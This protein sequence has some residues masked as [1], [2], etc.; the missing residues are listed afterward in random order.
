MKFRRQH[1]IGPFVVDFCCPDRRLV[2]ELDG[3]VHLL[4]AQREHDAEREALLAA[5]GYT[6]LR[7]PNAT[8]H[9]DLPTLLE[10]IRT[11][12]ERQPPSPP[13]ST[14]THRRLVTP[15]QAAGTA[16]SPLALRTCDALAPCYLVDTD[17]AVPSCL[18]LRPPATAP[19]W[20]LWVMGVVMAHSACQ[21]AV[22]S[23]S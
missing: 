7:F 16:Q 6:V 5:A 12:A 10:T 14:P 15:P 1:P 23:A 22:L 17:L 19:D 2:V 8:V 18:Q 3:P 21:N 20:S 9:N 11:A 4:P 13:A